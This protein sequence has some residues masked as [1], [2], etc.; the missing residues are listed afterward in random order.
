MEK[1]ALCRNEARLV[2][3]HTVPKFAVEWLK[4]SSAT[5]YLR[6]ALNPNR[7]LQDVN[8]V[9][10]LCSDCENRF[11]KWEKQFAQKLFTPYTE[12][13]LQSFAYDE[14]LLYFAVSLAWRTTIYEAVEYRRTRP[15]LA[16]FVDEAIEHWS[17]FL[18][19]KSTEAG[20]YEHHIVFLSLLAGSQPA[21]ELPV[22]LEAYL[23]R[24]VDTTLASNTKKVFACTKLPGIAFCSAIH[25]SQLEG[26][27]LHTLIERK[28]HLETR[29]RVGPD[30]GSF[31][32]NRVKQYEK[33]A[34]EIS[35]RQLKLIAE[36]GAKNP[37][38]VF[39]SQDF[40]VFMR[41]IMRKSKPN[42]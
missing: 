5:P 25:P 6:S 2:N 24:A 33:L 17:M 32:V 7:R 8:T 40:V 9:K 19:G 22:N 37:A 10:L 20:P 29:Q 21:A 16:P 35:E 4:K 42:T 39:S 12:G 28:G 36:S 38:R 1:C 18:Q 30:I 26:E 13:S 41:K 15:A 3:S 14:W 23:L 31:L 27:Y 34:P 11:S